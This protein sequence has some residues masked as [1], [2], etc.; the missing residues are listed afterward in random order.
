[1]QVF[2]IF[3]FKH[4]KLK[5]FIIVSQRRLRRMVRLDAANYCLR[6]MRIQLEDINPSPLKILALDALAKTL[7]SISV[8]GLKFFN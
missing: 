7:M 1:M 5:Q 2:L 8:K 3:K 6:A 4:F